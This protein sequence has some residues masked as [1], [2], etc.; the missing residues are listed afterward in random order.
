MN[1]HQNWVDIS[2]FLEDGKIM[3]KIRRRF[4]VFSKQGD[5]IGEVSYNDDVLQDQK[6]YYERIDGP[7][8]TLKSF[9]SMQSYKKNYVQK[10]SGQELLK[11][12]R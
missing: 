8:Q 7:K 2:T 12:R 6:P 4:M 9:R 1:D 3:I 10:M 11:V 5:F